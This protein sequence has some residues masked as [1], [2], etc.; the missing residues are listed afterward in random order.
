MRARSW[1][2]AARCRRRCTLPA[3]RTAGADDVLDFAS[4]DAGAQQDWVRQRTGGRGADVVFEATGD[5]AAVVQAMRCARDAGR[6]VVVGQYTDRGEATFHPHRDLNKKHLDVL[7]CWGS[8]YSHF[9]RA[10][11]V[12]GHPRLGRPWAA[13]P[14]AEFTLRDVE[15]ALQATARGEV[16]KA[17]VR[18]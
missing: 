9:H 10:V 13:L 6:V 17:L 14:V 3:A 16:V 8:D 1:S 4:C 11:Q 15:R 12:V 2:R 5:P 18:P 7:G